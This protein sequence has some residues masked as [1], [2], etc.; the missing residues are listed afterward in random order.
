MF[1]KTLQVQ[2][3]SWAS[4]GQFSMVFVQVLFSKASSM[5]GVSP[6]FSPQSQLL[7]QLHQCKPLM[8]TGE[9]SG[10]AICTSA[11]SLSVKQASAA[12]VPVM[13]PGAWLAVITTY[14]RHEGE[15]ERSAKSPRTPEHKSQLFGGQRG[16]CCS[17]V[18]ESTEP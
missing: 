14:P 4:E 11:V 2:R 15:R 8:A 6:D 7:E 13:Q 10:V 9:T 16:E 3:G 1:V 18:T 12:P 17:K 5:L